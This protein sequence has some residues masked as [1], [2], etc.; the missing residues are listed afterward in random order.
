[1]NEV[2]TATR[3]YL[4]PSTMISVFNHEALMHECM[5]HAWDVRKDSFS[6]VFLTV[7]TEKIVLTDKTQHMIL[8]NRWWTDLNRCDLE[9]EQFSFDTIIVLRDFYCKESEWFIALPLASIQVIYTPF[10]MTHANLDSTVND[11]VWP[12]FDL[13]KTQPNVAIL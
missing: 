7:L 2:Y 4:G 3:F 1:M 13:Y 10:F 11:H 9:L 6:L 5:M 12:C 8:S